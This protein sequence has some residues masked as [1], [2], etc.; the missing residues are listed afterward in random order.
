[1]QFRPAMKN[2]S[3]FGKTIALSLSLIAV[4]I[5]AQNCGSS[6]S[7]TAP[8][9]ASPGSPATRQTSPLPLGP[10]YRSLSQNIFTP[11]CLSCHSGPNPSGN[12]NFTSY[13]ALVHNPRHTDLVTPGKP[14]NSHLYEVLQNDEM[15]PNGPP[16]SQQEIQAVSDWIS[17]GA[18]NN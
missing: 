2:T 16:L 13:D 9:T 7:A 17:S 12:T 3:C 18:Q 14:E 4:A 15:P 5:L 1:M 10:S 8:G 6:D 11:K